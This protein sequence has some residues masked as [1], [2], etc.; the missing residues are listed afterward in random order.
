LSSHGERQAKS[1]NLRI[2]ARDF[3]GQ[4]ASLNIKLLYEENGPVQ[5]E[6]TFNYILPWDQANLIETEDLRLYFPEGSLYETLYLKLQR[7]RDESAEYYSEVYHVHTPEV[8]LHRPLQI[9]IRPNGDYL[10]GKYNEL[11]DYAIQID[12]TPPSIQALSFGGNM[13]G[14]KRMSFRIYDETR[15]ARHVRG[16]EWK[17]YVDGQLGNEEKFKGAFTL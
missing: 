12:T 7:S 3:H 11:G 17:A 2:E 14:R 16:I 15:T 13:R 5:N 8:P 9:S 1:Q 6:N 4:T 10:I